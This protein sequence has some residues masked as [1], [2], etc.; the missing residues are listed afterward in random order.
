MLRNE[1]QDT[2]ASPDSACEWV[3]VSE[4]RWLPGRLPDRGA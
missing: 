3:G 1:L 4:P 2:E